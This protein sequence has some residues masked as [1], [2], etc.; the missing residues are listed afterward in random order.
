MAASETVAVSGGVPSG[1]GSRGAAL[2]LKD[3][4]S[5]FGFFGVSSSSDVSELYQ[6]AALRLPSS[7]I[8]RTVFHRSVLD[9]IR[10]PQFISIIKTKR[11]PEAGSSG[12][13][14]LAKRGLYCLSV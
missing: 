12:R 3:S 10:F 2:S 14:P 5:A 7:A 9:H 6:L 11:E 1:T 13:L 8:L 4:V